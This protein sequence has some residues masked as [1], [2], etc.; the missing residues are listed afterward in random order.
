MAR[1]GREL[2]PIHTIS[3]LAHSAARSKLE[4]FLTNFFSATARPRL[5]DNPAIDNDPTDTL[6]RQD[7]SSTET[8]HSSQI[9]DKNQSRWFSLSIS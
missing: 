6:R 5:D 3:S 8:R 1:D 2:G 7:I 9:S 4:P